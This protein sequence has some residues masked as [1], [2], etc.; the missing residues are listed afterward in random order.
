MEFLNIIILACQVSSGSTIIE[1]IMNV[2]R[3]C[4]RDIIGCVCK[5]LGPLKNPEA[6][7]IN[8]ATLECLLEIGGK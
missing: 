8:T 7:K 5:K 6:I 3:S 4:Q 2:Q 1:N